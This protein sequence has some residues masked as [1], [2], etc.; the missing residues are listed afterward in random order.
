[1]SILNNLKDS[2]H[3]LKG[4]TPAQ[5]DAAKTTSTL[6]YKSSITD[7]PDILAAQTT[8]SLKGKKPANNYLVNLPEV[9]IDQ[10]AQ[11]LTQ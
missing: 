5:R 9:G 2:V 1:M 3:G 10:R 11:D 7:D 6:H 8:L 4:Q